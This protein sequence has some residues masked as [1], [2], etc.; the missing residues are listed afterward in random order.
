MMVFFF[1]LMSILTSLVI[2]PQ[3]SHIFDRQHI[4]DSIGTLQLEAELLR[5]FVK[6]KQQHLESLAASPIV[7]NS[8]L[9]ASADDPDLLDLLNNYIINTEKAHLLL[10]DIAGGVIYKTDD[11]IK[12]DFSADSNW[13][14]ALI[15]QK[16]SYNFK[17][18][19]QE[20]DQL[21][22]ILSVPVLYQGSTEGVLSAYISTPIDHVFSPQLITNNS[23]FKLKQNN[24]IAK[25][26]SDHI[27]MPKEVSTIMVEKNL[28]LIYVSDATYIE[29]ERDRINGVILSVIFMGF[30]VS[31]FIFL[32]FNI[33]S[34]KNEEATTHKTNLLNYMV[35][36]CVCLFGMTASISASSLLNSILNNQ[37]Y[38]DV[39]AENNVQILSVVRSI[40]QHIE[41]LNSLRSFW[42]AS[43]FVSRNDFQNFIAPML[44]KHENIEAAI[45]VPH[46]TSNERPELEEKARRDGIT[47]YQILE[48]NKDG[49][50]VTAKDRD[51][52][53]PV[54]FAAP[55]SLS[56]KLLG[57][58]LL[59]SPQSK[60]AM[61][62]AEKLGTSIASA[63][64][65]F[66]TPDEKRA[67]IVIFNPVFK[68]T[69]EGDSILE[70]HVGVILLIDQ[71][72][73][74]V[75]RTYFHST[76]IFILDITQENDPITI[77]GGMNLKN[78]HQ[79]LALV[80][81]VNIAGRQWEF[82]AYPNS[83]FHSNINNSLPWII[84]FLGCL[85][86]AAIT[87]TLV[88]LIR[89]NQANE[90]LKEIITLKLSD[91]ENKM[92][93]IVDST[94]DG[95]ITINKNGIVESY[96]DACSKIFGYNYDEVVGRNI[97]MLMPEPYKSEHDKYLKNYQR[98]GTKK[99]IGTGREVEG[100]R[101]DGST[102]PLELA[103][104]E[105]KIHGR[106]LYAGVLRDI[107][108]RK[109][110]EARIL[111]ANE[112]LKLLQESVENIDSMIAIAEA[113]DID[114][115][116]KIIYASGGIEKMSGYA[117][118]E[119]LGKSPFILQCEETDKKI[120]SQIRNCLIQEVE[121]KG[122]LLNQHKDGSTF[123]AHM[124]IYP[125]KD[126]QGKVKYFTFVQRD[127]TES[128]AVIQEIIRSNVELERFAYLASH[129]L[130]EPLRMVTNF[131]SLLSKKYEDQLDETAQEYIKFAYDGAKRMQELVNDLLE[132][133]RVG[134]D[135]ESYEEVEF[136]QLLKLTEDNLQ[137]AI[138]ESGAKIIYKP[139]DCPVILTNPVRLI[140]VLQN[141]IGNAIKYR[142][143][144]V[145]P[146]INIRIE[147][148]QDFWAFTFQDNGIGMKQKYENK[149][150][151]PFK[152]L[153]KNNAYSGTGM[154]L[155][156]CRKIIEG[157]GGRIWI[158]SELDKGSTFF[159]TIPK[160]AS[161]KG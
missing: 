146:E 57:F 32:L 136:L 105:V 23:A 107:S 33:Y 149:I 72:V 154:G 83:D 135:A 65:E 51:R 47:N 100:K 74:T 155:A 124:S 132:Y 30:L 119:L 159:F 141:L 153:H 70:G 150:F 75:K 42:D 108:E 140:R 112:Q 99:I 143:E 52:Y 103:V 152:R 148:Q 31:F 27:Q 86:S 1:M 127:I 134:P 20:G 4:R 110:A 40:E 96:N 21:R 126:A 16:T 29:K 92:Q 34:F 19:P 48:R 113:G 14:E 85:F 3:L 9:L 160:Q 39:L 64:I 12:G 22:F 116:M 60:E 49:L 62:Q 45:W 8:A 36:I 114:D 5:R 41:V 38:Q 158:K 142:K 59:M 106:I 43:D 125:I 25:T 91:S 80:E 145:A 71:I 102:F 123:W 121:F 24:I 89:R 90:Q 53:A 11:K 131:T 54:F 101:K 109:E 137:E 2:M 118:H 44:I 133:A 26:K 79:D 144:G 129:D 122:E 104:A 87:F 120:I 10:Q 93:A 7:I 76:S 128:R 147:D 15:T 18:L 68:T 50:E 84:L 117:P 88:Q 28:E 94:V 17:L 37:K 151:E 58:D 35:P 73:D 66:G 77:Y 139:E 130:Q 98:T 69:D 111:E 115:D 161:K 156:I 82:I 67:A 138:N 81:T 78:M 6:D 97:I 157:F 13:F 56:E 63:P 55:K 95:I 61:I 46:I